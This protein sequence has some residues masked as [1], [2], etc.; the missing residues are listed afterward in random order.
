MSKIEQGFLYTKEHEWVKVEGEFATVGISDHAQHALSDI[1]YVE[2][3]DIDAEF[4]KGDEVVV[5][6]SAKAAASVYA[7]ASGTIIEVNETLQG[8]PGVVNEDC[9][10][11][12]WIYKIKLTNSADLE[13]LMDSSSY[14]EFQASEE[15]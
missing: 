6:E 12:G 4:K 13:Q 7:P 10:G 8:D 14:D 15:D 2:L 3:P 9:Y 5:I 1:V 11:K